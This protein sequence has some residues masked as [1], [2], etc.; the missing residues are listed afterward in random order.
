MLLF[1]LPGVLSLRLEERALF[2]SLFHPP[3]RSTRFA[4]FGSRPLTA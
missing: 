3:P 4:V 2:A 1:V